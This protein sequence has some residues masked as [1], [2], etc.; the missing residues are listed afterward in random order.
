MGFIKKYIKKH[1]KKLISE[2]LNEGKQYN[3]VSIPVDLIA[4]KLLHIIQNS[5]NL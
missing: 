5:E 2:V 3:I 4:S 1:L